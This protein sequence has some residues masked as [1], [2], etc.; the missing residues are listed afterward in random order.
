MA[1]LVTVLVMVGAF[2]H[3]S[4]PSAGAVATTIYANSASGNDSSGNGTAGNPYKTFHKAYTVAASGDTID[5]TGTFT[6]TDSGETGDASGTGYTISKNLT[7]QGQ[8]R[9]T[10]VQAAS[11][12]NTADR[13]VFFI[14]T[15]ATVT[16]RNLTVRHGKVVADGYGGGI[17]LYGQ[18]CG[19]PGGCSGTT[20]VLTLDQVDVTQ[21]DAATALNTYTYNRAGGVMLQENANLTVLDSNIEDNNCTCKYYAAGGIYGG[22]QSSTITIS[23]SSISSNTVNSDGGSTYPYDYTSVAG[24]LAMQRFGKLTV[25]NSTFYGNSTNSYGGAMSVYYS[26]RGTRLTNVTVVGNSATL[27]AGGILWNQLYTGSNYDLR[28]KNVM[29]ANNTGVSGAS[30]DFYAKDATSGSAVV[31]T[32]SIIESSTNKVFS[33]T[34]IVTGNQ[35]SL[36]VDSA[37]DVNGA[38]KGSHTLA[39]L[40]GSVAID[41]GDS[42]A[43][44]YTGN[45]VT[46][47]STDQRGSARVGTY[48]IGAYEFGGAVPT[49]TTTAAPTTTTTVP[50]TTTTVPATTTT[51]PATTTT[52]LAT[53]TTAAAASTSTVAVASSS[54]VAVSSSS[55][56]ALASQTSAVAAPSS[57]AVPQAPEA[58]SAVATPATVPP[59][60]KST[61]DVLA[62]G[63]APATTVAPPTT[64]TSTI[65]PETT[66]TIPAPDAPSAQPGSA[67]ATVDGESVATTLSRINNQLVISF[68]SIKITVSAV[69]KS[70]QVLPLDAEG[71]LRLDKDRQVRLQMTN[72]AVGADVQVWLFSTPTRLGSF[73]VGS[74]GELNEVVE[75]SKDVPDGNHRLVVQQETKRGSRMVFAVG[76][77]IGPK[78]SSNWS[79]RWIV[80]PPLGLASIAALVIPA[81]RRRRKS[82]TA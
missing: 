59:V 82:A 67:A 2:V 12:R 52:V 10:I 34:G 35:A 40:S 69:D 8:S 70:G 60:V 33:G 19:T 54:S 17:T 57:I 79:I 73:I 20:G 66:T 9:S 23:N 7:I 71:N 30:N 61:T 5:L 49:T 24:G 38:A 42:A 1:R 78:S 62:I 18:Y 16:M 45:T 80:L 29:L 47:P 14:N 31:S 6:W 81:R 3:V 22:Y 64:S 46:P 41:A 77:I 28:M 72:M 44:G 56:V 32:Y 65:P 74:T 48:D 21:N 55:S 13:M 68:G 15:G 11:T 50:A 58:T 37:I 51:V 53:T 39:L 76:V 25:T 75:V 27:G 36:N 63:R 4:V 43:H 26:D